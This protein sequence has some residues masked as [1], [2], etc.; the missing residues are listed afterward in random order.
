MQQNTDSSLEVGSLVSPQAQRSFD[1]QSEHDILALL[2]FIHINPIDVEKKNALRDH[3][4][5]YRQS[6][7]PEHLLEIAAILSPLGISVTSG[8]QLLTAEARSAVPFKNPIGVGRP[9][10]RFR[11]VSVQQAAPAGVQP[12]QESMASADPLPDAETQT[13]IP[14][15]AAP[16]PAVP[17]PVSAPRTEEVSSAI[18]Y[19]D[20]MTRIQE[21]KRIVN[22]KVGNP[23]KLIE[24]HSE[25]GHEYMSALLD[26]MKKAPGGGVQGDLNA[27]MDRLEAAFA[28]VSALPAPGTASVAPEASVAP[29]TPQ[30]P[31]VAAEPA[32]DG[33]LTAL[34]RQQQAPYESTLTQ[35][36]MVHTAPQQENVAPVT[37]PTPMTDN[38]AAHESRFASVKRQLEVADVLPKQA[39]AVPDA[40]EEQQAPAVRME[41]P[42]EHPPLEA[43]A[44]EPLPEIHSVGK[45]KQLQDL[46]RA[47]HQK[48]ATAKL[49]IEEERIASMD[50]LQTPEVTAGLSQLLSEWSLFK[51]SGIFGIGPSGKDH[52]L[53]KRIAPLTMAA[54]IAGR[55][56]GATP[57]I[58]Q[59]ITDYM[60]GWR[61][62][63]GIVH[64]HG[65]TFEHYLRRV[66]HHILNKKKLAA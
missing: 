54:V 56:E 16:Q 63:E 39:A 57:Q 12:K 62:E 34:D 55:F 15:Q 2:R 48:E 42:I 37:Q 52:V 19:R 3:I 33:T 30:M 51:S 60:N 23:V 28:K 5:T 50:P 66:I 41:Q 32:Y 64:E 9:Q 7:D 35:K 36:A 38:V 20:P 65:E 45:E 47:K 4:F 43:Q 27:A 61:Y 29:Q 13:S 18:E 53:Y 17:D 44:L 26:A 25:I 6:P 24:S 49:Q 40:S 11:T 22:Q 8:E 59:S 1:V 21:I 58:K 31:P 10:P 14:V 46:L